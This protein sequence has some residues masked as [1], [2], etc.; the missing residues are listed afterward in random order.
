[1]KKQKSKA[2]KLAKAR[3]AVERE[4][5]KKAERKVKP[6]KT[7]KPET[8]A[9][10]VAPEL[11]DRGFAEK[12]TDELHEDAARF[13]AEARSGWIKLGA[14]AL[15]GVNLQIHKALGLS[16]SGWLK[17]TFGKPWQSYRRAMLACRALL[18]V[19]PIA[20]LELMTEAKAYNFSLLP[21]ELQS[22]KKWIAKATDPEVE[23]KEFAEEVYEER[24][25]RGLVYE[26]ETPIWEAF[27]IGSLPETFCK[28]SVPLAHKIA[29]KLLASEGY[30]I[31]PNTKQGTATVIEK[32]YAEFIT[33]QQHLLE[34][35]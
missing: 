25:A 5:K 27:Q 18:P 12:F 1:M 15:E 23:G 34:A 17:T 6:A 24:K 22:D 16:E 20:K 28:E 11:P 35:N 2:G 30:E 29:V 31:D 10:A 8:A 14:R 26:K 9:L 19:V 3:A 33:S 7:S 4:Q 32:I 13:E 21:P